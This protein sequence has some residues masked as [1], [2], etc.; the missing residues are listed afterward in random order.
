[1]H[2]EKPAIKMGF[3]KLADEIKY[4]SNVLLEG[5]FDGSNSWS[6]SSSAQEA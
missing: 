5:L 2:N 4:S 6:G 1:M 3:V